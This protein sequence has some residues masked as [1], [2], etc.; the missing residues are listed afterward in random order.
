MYNILNTPLEGGPPSGEGP[1][2]QRQQ[3]HTQVSRGRGNTDRSDG[4][5]GG[6]RRGD[7]GGRDIT[8]SPPPPKSRDQRQERHEATE[9][10]AET[11]EE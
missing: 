1:E 8:P 10:R 7:T 9:S 4:G 6:G 11:E 5:R 3:V 2:P